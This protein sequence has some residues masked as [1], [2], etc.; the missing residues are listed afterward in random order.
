MTT[1]N[2]KLN[3]VNSFINAEPLVAEWALK[4]NRESTMATIA[5]RVWNSSMLT[6]ENQIVV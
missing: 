3:T 2:Y 6:F 1:D 5:S 4:T